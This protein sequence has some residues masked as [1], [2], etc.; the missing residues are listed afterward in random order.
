[1]KGGVHPLAGG[2]RPRTRLNALSQTLAN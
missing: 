1:M 2:P